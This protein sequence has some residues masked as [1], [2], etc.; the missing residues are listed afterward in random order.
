LHLHRR[1]GYLATP[2]AIRS[3][4]DLVGLAVEEATV[5]QA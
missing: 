4:A 2:H 5:G 1:I 3:L